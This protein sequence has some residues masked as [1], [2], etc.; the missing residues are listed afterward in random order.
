MAGLEPV[1]YRIRRDLTIDTDDLLA[2]ASSDIA[3]VLII[4]FFGFAPDLS[5]LTDLRKFDIRV[6]EDCSHAFLAAHPQQ[7][8]GSEESD[9]R[10]FSFWKIVACGVGGGLWRRHQPETLGLGGLTA[11]RRGPAL[12][13]YKLLFEEAIKYSNHD[14]LHSA[15]SEI[16]RIRLRFKPVRQGLP[17]PMATLEHG[18]D[19]YPVDFQLANSGMPQHVRRII[20]ASNLENVS[21]RRRENFECYS[22][23]SALLSPLQP[24][25]QQLGPTTC[26]WVY[27]VLLVNRSKIDFKLRNA[28][29]SLHTFG[30]YLH[31]ALFRNT[32][33]A[34]ISDASHLAGHVLCLSIHQNLHPAEIERNCNLITQIS[35]NKSIL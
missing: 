13:N 21:R 4:H 30:I 31:S 26:P 19:Y 12:R 6:I 24:I 10:A 33:S 9:Y 18:E 3:A 8:A 20:G 27:P 15:L 1:F 22:S 2:K 5:F 29:V 35:N 14:W 23:R 25:F 16:E 7:L 11:L 17:I 28:G 32:D 34:T